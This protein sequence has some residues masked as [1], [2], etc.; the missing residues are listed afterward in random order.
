MTDRELLKIVLCEMSQDELSSLLNRQGLETEQGKALHDFLRQKDVEE[1][2]GKRFALETQAVS[3]PDTLKLAIYRFL[4]RIDMEEPEFYKKCGISKDHYYQ[5]RDGKIKRARNKRL[6]FRFVL[7]LR[8][9]YFE[10][11]YLLNLGGHL[12][13]PSLSMYDYIIAHCL[14]RKIYDFD[15]VDELLEKYGLES[16]WEKNG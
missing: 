14:Y 11:V 9:D 15:A 4:R 6:F 10:A 8:L 7:I 3:R 13:N 2:M 5:I 1:A 16:I 12:F